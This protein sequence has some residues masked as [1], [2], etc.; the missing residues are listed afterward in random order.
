M[1][2]MNQGSKIK[3]GFFHFYSEC[4]KIA[5]VLWTPSYN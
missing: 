2:S 5:Y 4:N 1:Q 3:L